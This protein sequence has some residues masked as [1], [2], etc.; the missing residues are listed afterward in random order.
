MGSVA[1]THAAQIQESDEGLRRAEQTW[2]SSEPG[3][4]LLCGGQGLTSDLRAFSLPGQGFW[5]GDGQL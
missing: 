2:A 3:F 1:S 4:T 5:L